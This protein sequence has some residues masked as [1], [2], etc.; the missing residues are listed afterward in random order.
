M[1]AQIAA[2][3]ESQLGRVRALLQT[4]EQRQQRLRA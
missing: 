1:A 4:V 2:T 3:P